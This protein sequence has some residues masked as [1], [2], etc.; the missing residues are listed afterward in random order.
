MAADQQATCPRC[1]GSGY[2]QL[3]RGCGA[4]EDW[5]CPDCDGPEREPDHPAATALQTIEAE[6]LTDQLRDVTCTAWTCPACGWDEYKAYGLE[7]DQCG[8]D[9]AP[10]VPVDRRG[11]P[12][13]RVPVGYE[14]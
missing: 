5:E 8:F 9:V 6:R 2:V 11:K 13:V 12:V 14:P 7:C 10:F 3:D 1:D 4:W